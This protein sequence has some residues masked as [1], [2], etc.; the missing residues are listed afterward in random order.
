MLFR[1][2]TFGAL[3][4]ATNLKGDEGASTLARFMNVMGEDYDNVQNVGSAIVDLGNHTATTEKEIATMATRMGSAASIIGFSTSDVLGYAA[5]LSSTG[6][7]AE[8]GGSAMTRIWQSI[9]TEV[10]T[11]GEGLDVLAKKSNMTAK[12]FADAWKSSPAEAFN[13][14]L[15]GLSESDNMVLDLQELGINNV[16]D[17]QSIEKLAGRYDL[18]TASLQR[19]NQAYAEGKALSVE[20]NR[21]YATTASKLQMAK[22]S[23]VQASREIGGA[24]A[25]SIVELGQKVTKG[26]NAFKQLDD[27]T[28]K[29][30]AR[31]ALWAAGTIMATNTAG[32]FIKNLGIMKAGMI[33]LAGSFGLGA[34]QLTPVGIVQIGRASCRER[35]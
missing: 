8:M 18:V 32:K 35:V 15:K 6:V 19:A 30:I 12:Q 21:A 17:I 25:P 29:N 9:E 5:A 10:A 20:A 26:A 33:K 22:E 11:T 28:Q 34:A 2:E 4:V 31:N 3:E 13:A 27:T 23:V 16:R 24:L 1:S 7:A 14:L